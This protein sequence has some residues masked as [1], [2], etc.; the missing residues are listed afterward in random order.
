MPPVGLYF[1]RPVPYPLATQWQ[2]AL[3]D[4][5]IRNEI[6]DVVLF[7]EHPPT[8]TLGRRGR[9][10]G[11]KLPAGTYEHRGIALHQAARGGDVTY[12]APG[13]L[14]IYPI[15]RLGEREA[16]AHGYLHNLEE[17]AMC[18]AGDFGLETSRKTGKNGV[19]TPKGK[20]AAI[21]FH[22]KKWVTSHGMS[23]NVDLDLTGFTTIVPC[24]L[25]GEPVTSLAELLGKEHCPSLSRVRARWA[26]HF[27]RI[28]D[29][30]LDTIG[31]LRGDE[32]TQMILKHP[33][34]SRD[35]QHE[36]RNAQQE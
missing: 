18:T 17:I 30:P 29:R 15:L 35:T 23:F 9:T 11:L 36:T 22:L 13:Q 8:V 31:H 26:N 28:C 12:H 3:R 5:R 1:E 25:Q 16:D 7:L 10:S 32:T 33:A 34:L 24:G 14:V 20:L 21:G 4:A 2:Q 19:W 6:P 27:G